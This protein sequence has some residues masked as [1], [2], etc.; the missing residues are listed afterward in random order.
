M[1]IFELLQGQ[2]FKKMTWEQQKFLC[3]IVKKD[4]EKA[5]KESNLTEQVVYYYYT[6]GL[7]G[8]DRDIPDMDVKAG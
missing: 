2:H 5:A 8:G 3:K 4:V 6:K 7:Y 1:R